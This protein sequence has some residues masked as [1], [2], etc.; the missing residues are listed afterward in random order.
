METGQASSDRESRRCLITVL[1]ISLRGCIVK[2]TGRLAG[3]SPPLHRVGPLRSNSGSQAGRQGPLSALS[4]GRD[5]NGDAGRPRKESQYRQRVRED[6]E[7][8]KVR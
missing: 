1:F 5:G 6:E 4:Q 7:K 3:N 2:L 8:K